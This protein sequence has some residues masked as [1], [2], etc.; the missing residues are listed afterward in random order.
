MTEEQSLVVDEEAIKKSIRSGIPVTI[1]TYTLPRETEVYIA[2]VLAVF[3]RL[4]GHENLHDYI[5]YCVHE[6][7]SNAK[8][9]N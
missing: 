1:T 9:A 2:N 5:E 8:K 4:A 3:L 6:L 7:S